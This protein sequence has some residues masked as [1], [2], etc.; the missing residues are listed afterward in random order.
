VSRGPLQR[1]RMG[2]ELY[3]AMVA[4]LARVA[5]LEGCGL[6]ATEDD[7]AVKLYPGENI[8]RSRVR[9]TMDPRA[10]LLALLEIEAAGWRLGAIYHSHPEGPARPSATDL[11][12]ARVPDALAV[13]ISLAGP[14]APVAA[15][16]ALDEDQPREVPLVID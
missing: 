3:E 5:P 10:V 14:G 11:Q 6:I 9:Y 16:F 15:A 8:E 1:L 12:E 7:R 4:E 13:I 2:R